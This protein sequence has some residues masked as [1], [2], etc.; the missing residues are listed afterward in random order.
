MCNDESQEK[1]SLVNPRGVLVRIIVVSIHHKVDSL[2]RK[3]ASKASFSV[4]PGGDE[5]SVYKLFCD[6]SFLTQI[7]LGGPQKARAI[8]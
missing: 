7:L 8:S 1:R 4:A 3:N 6:E 2:Q 5:F